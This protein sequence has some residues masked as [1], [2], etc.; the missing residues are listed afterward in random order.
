MET[1]AAEGL[2]RVAVK[3]PA[4][5]LV[6]PGKVYSWCVCGLTLK[7]PFCDGSHKQ[8]EGMPFRSI[9]VQFEKAEE[10]WFCD[11]QLYSS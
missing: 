7:E 2:P 3:E 4:G 10:V 1:I 8:I 9:K 5:I 11:A 6:E